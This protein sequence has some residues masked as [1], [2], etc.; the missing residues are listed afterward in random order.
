MSQPAFAQG[1]SVSFQVFYDDL[2]PYGT[3]ID[4]PDYGYVWVPNEGGNFRP[5]ATNGYWAYTEQGWTWISNYQWGWAPFHYGRWYTDA[6]YGPMWVPGYEWGPGW[7][8]WRSSGTYYGWAPMG[9]GISISVAYG[10]GYYDT[11]NQY[12]FVPCNYMGRTTINN[13]YVNNS[14]N[15]TIINN[16]TVINNNRVDV[17][18]VSYSAGPQRAEVEKHAGRVFTPVAIKESSRPGQNLNKERLEIYRPQ[19]QQNSGNGSRPAPAKVANLKDERTPS[20]RKAEPANQKT[21]QPGRVNPAQSGQANPARK[22]ETQSQPKRMDPAVNPGGDRGQPA[23]QQPSRPERTGQP[24]KVN[25]TQ[26]QQGNP[27]LNPGGERNDRQAPQRP[28]QPQRVQPNEQRSQPMR[29]NEQPRQ[30]PAQ[31]QRVN[32]NPNNGGERG[33]QPTNRMPERMAQPKQQQPEQPRRDVQQQQP[34]Q[35]RRDVQQTPPQQ[36][37][38]QPRRDAQQAPPQQHQQQ[39]QPNPRVNTGGKPH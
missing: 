23:R 13:Y 28:D 30:Q 35:P 4:N 26:P 12:T 39:Q 11:Y 19:V 9:P 14:S 31:P 33:G 36:Q 8:S 34:E 22:V 6:T 1:G 38:V 3:W 10:S 2:S 7:V 15:T 25:P 21:A 20:E 29:N 32:P 5:Y 18:N 37:P 24:A 27:R 16:T 17:H